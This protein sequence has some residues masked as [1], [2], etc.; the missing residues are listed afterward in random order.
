MAVTLNSILSFVTLVAESLEKRI[1]GAAFS[2]A[3]GITFMATD[4]LAVG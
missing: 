3:K 1:V 4:L 2:G